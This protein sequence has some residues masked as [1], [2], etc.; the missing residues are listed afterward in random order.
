MWA[1]NQ[2]ASMWQNKEVQ[3]VMQADGP[4]PKDQAYVGA[5]GIE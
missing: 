2:K 5:G 4:G 1:A 3:L